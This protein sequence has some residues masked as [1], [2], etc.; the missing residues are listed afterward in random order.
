MPL[1]YSGDRGAYVLPSTAK[2]GQFVLAEFCYFAALSSFKPIGNDSYQLLA[3]SYRFLEYLVFRNKLLQAR[4]ASFDLI[5]NGSRILIVGGGNGIVLKYLPN[6]SVV[7]IDP[8]Q[9]MLRIAAKV[10]TSA[11]VTFINSTLELAE[12]QGGF[13][14]VLV[15]FVLDLYPAAQL[16][17]ALRK[18]SD[19]LKPGGMLHIADFKLSDLSCR[20]HF[21]RILTRF[22]ILFFRIF[23]DHQNRTVPDIPKAVGQSELLLQS[24]HT[25]SCGYIFNGVWQ[26]SHTL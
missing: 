17:S 20:D 25:T 8:S 6:S 7:F 1:L 16:D 2:L 9:K 14:H 22:M 21:Y 5:E 12:L 24:C 26:K 15:H 19:L 3:G 4:I 13:D 18:L 11:E 10:P 23:T